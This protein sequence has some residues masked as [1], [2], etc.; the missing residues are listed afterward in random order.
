MVHRGDGWSE[1]ATLSQ[2]GIFR[3]KSRLFAFGNGRELLM[4]DS[5]AFYDQKSECD[6][7]RDLAA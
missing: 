5:E 2:R 6:A 7:A 3:P 4:C 1:N